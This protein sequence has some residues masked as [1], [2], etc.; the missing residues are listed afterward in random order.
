M[1]IL[2]LLIQLREGL[3][4]I[5]SSFFRQ[6]AL[7]N[8]QQSQV[9]RVMPKFT[10]P[11]LIFLYWV[12]FFICIGAALAVWSY[13]IPYFEQGTGIMRRATAKTLSSYGLTGNGQK[14]EPI[15]ILFLA[16]RL[17]NHLHTGNQIRIQVVGTKQQLL[18]TVERLDETLLTQDEARQRY[19]LSVQ[20]AANIPPAAFVAF[21]GFGTTMISSENDGRSVTVRIQIGTKNVLSLF[22]QPGLP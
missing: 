8:Y 20:T 18:G 9:P 21:I 5:K 16:E 1:R 7:E 11:I 17:R 19:A 14:S 15:A 3:C 2:D 6:K 10:P 13:S 12:L 4:M 22:S